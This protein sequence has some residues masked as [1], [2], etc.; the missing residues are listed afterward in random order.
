VYCSTSWRNIAELSPDEDLL[1]FELP[2]EESDELSE[3]FEKE[4]ASGAPSRSTATAEATRERVVF[5]MAG[6]EA[7][8][9]ARRD[10][11]ESC[12]VDPDRRAGPFT[13]AIEASVPSGLSKFGIGRAGGPRGG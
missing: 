8:G 10:V 13:R 9:G 6:N 7:Q 3:L 11:A 2:L 12:R 5:V 4:Q 1:E